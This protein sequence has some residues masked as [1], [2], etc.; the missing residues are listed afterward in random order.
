MERISE[1][2]QTYL[3]FNYSFFTLL[4]FENYVKAVVFASRLFLF[5]DPLF[6]IT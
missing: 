6:I 3:E 2:F 5:E 4:A 1:T